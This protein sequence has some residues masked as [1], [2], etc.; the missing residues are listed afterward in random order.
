MRSVVLIESLTTLVASQTYVVASDGLV[1]V[2]F[3]TLVISLIPD[4][5]SVIVTDPPLDSCTKSPLGSILYHWMMGLGLPVALQV[6]VA[7][8]GMVTVKSEGSSAVM[9]GATGGKMSI[10]HNLL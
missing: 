2:M 5:V 3:R 4:D 10:Q 9:V 1:L 6:N 7:G 8:V